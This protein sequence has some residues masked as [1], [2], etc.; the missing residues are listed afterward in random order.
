MK[1]S[2]KVLKRKH[3]RCTTI[4]TSREAKIPHN[5]RHALY[6]QDKKGKTRLLSKFGPGCHRTKRIIDAYEDPVLDQFY[7]AMNA[8]D[9]EDSAAWAVCQYA[10][11]K[12][13]PATLLRAWAVNQNLHKNRELIRDRL[14]KM[15]IQH[16]VTMEHNQRAT[17]PLGWDIRLVVSESV[18]GAKTHHFDCYESPVPRDKL[19]GNWDFC[20]FLNDWTITDIDPVWVKVSN[21]SDV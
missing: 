9:M 15:G 17:H 6:Y 20:F 3:R 5:M 4:R 2:N 11:R 19:Q 16:P 21:H 1:L 12:N 10:F 7:M 18:D 13:D 14:I 8:I